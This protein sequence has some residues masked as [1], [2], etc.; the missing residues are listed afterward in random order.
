MPLHPLRAARSLRLRW[1]AAIAVA[2][3]VLAAGPAVA[4]DDR[5]AKSK[6]D[7]QI[8]QLKGQLADSSAAADQAAA[9]LAQTRT[10]LA[11][12]QQAAAAAQGALDAARAK[13]QAL[14]DQV[15][16]AQDDVA[17]STARIAATQ[18]HL[19]QVRSELGSVARQ[20]YMSGGADQL[21][22][23]DL[24]LSAKDMTSFTEAKAIT[25]AVANKENGVVADLL[26]T[27]KQL[28]DE[29]AKLQAR[30]ARLSALHGQAAQAVQ[31]SAGLAAQADAA[32]A[33]VAALER[34]Q[35]AALAT[36]EK[37]KAREQDALASAQRESAALAKRIADAQRRLAAQLAAEQAA[38]RRRAAAPAPA[39]PPAASRGGGA[40]LV[41][42]ASGPLFGVVGPRTNP[43]TGSLSCHAGIDIAAGYGTPILAAADG[44]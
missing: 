30:Q 7:Q 4:Q 32:Q 24:M 27:A 18:A 40:G 34:T 28:A 43:A 20:Q 17:R 2:G 8:G 35:A 6:V 29:K 1:V 36:I 22:L 37:E 12:A 39:A 44:I 38:K 11:Q 10:K 25:G 13:E 5:A 21:A 3:L 15:A 16:Q 19:D 41:W 26:S 23:V 14:A 33:Q 9:T 31:T 42:P